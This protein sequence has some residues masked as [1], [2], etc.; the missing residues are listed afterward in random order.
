MRSSAEKEDTKLAAHAGEEARRTG[1]FV[2]SRCNHKVHVS[3]GDKIPKCPNCGNDSFDE[4]RDEP[5]N[6]SS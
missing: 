3:N 6:K 1:D 4:R 2:C 5:G